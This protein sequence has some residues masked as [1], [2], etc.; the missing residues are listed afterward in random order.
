M[1]HVMASSI[2]PKGSS[3]PVV[4]LSQCDMMSHGIHFEAATHACLAVHRS[5]SFAQRKSAPCKR[6][7]GVEHLLLGALRIG[8]EHF[9]IDYVRSSGRKAL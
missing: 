6:R 4:M 3:P 8:P 7:H 1:L 5:M 9:V 2:A